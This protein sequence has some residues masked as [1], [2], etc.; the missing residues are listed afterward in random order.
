MPSSDLSNRCYVFTEGFL[1]WNVRRHG[2]H[3]LGINKDP[4]EGGGPLCHIPLSSHYL[5]S[6][7]FLLH[8]FHFRFA[9]RYIAYMLI[10]VHK[11]P[12][13]SCLK[14]MYKSLSLILYILNYQLQMQ[15]SISV[16]G[17]GWG[18]HFV[19]WSIDFPF[20]DR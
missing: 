14:Q 1:G 19:S 6:N 3:W 8:L 9:P 17:T 4:L 10:S 7:S 18:K 11:D 13:V 5:T 15:L 16:L 2:I 20:N 12:T